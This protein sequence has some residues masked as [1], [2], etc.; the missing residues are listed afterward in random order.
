MKPE[1]WYNRIVLFVAFMVEN[2]LQS[3]TIRTYI[4][5][6]KGVLADE[7]IHIDNNQFLL[8]ALTKACRL[9]NDRYTRGC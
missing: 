1:E 2:D 5:A 3:S 4:S 9:K 8:T 6:L 7:N